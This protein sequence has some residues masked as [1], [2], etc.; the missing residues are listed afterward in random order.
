MYQPKGARIQKHFH[1]QVQTLPFTLNELFVYIYR[2]TKQ[3]NQKQSEFICRN[4]E[5]VSRVNYKQYTFNF[6]RKNY[7]KR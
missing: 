7:W 5:I 3:H 6:K 2:K 4:G 1:F